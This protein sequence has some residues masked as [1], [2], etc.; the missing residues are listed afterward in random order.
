MIQRLVERTYK[1]AVYYS[2]YNVAVDVI[3]A[4]G[5]HVT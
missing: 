4:L 5:R 2:I 1:Y 3:S